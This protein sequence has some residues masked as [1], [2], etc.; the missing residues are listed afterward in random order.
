MVEEEKHSASNHN[1]LSDKTK[2]SFR[3][4][5]L[6]TNMKRISFRGKEL[7]LTSC[8]DMIEVVWL[9]KSTKSGRGRK[10][11]SRRKR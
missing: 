8:Y 6:D 4:R 3:D 10:S 7:G 5:N 9:V 2:S 1:V 11:G